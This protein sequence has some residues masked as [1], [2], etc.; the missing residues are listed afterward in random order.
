[1]TLPEIVLTEYTPS[2]LPTLQQWWKDKDVLEYVHELEHQLEGD[3]P[4]SKVGAGKYI[5]RRNVRFMVRDAVTGAAVGFICVQ[6]TGASWTER[7][8]EPVM[9]PFHGGVNIVIDPLRQHGG[10]GPAALKALFDHPKLENLVTLGG[11][12][13]A[14]NKASLG[15]LRKLGYVPSGPAVKGMVPFTVPGPAA[16]RS[17]TVSDHR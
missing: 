10:I 15:M 7:E 6:V 14:A 9:P 2:D 12:V 8:G 13:D 4:G 3:T 5:A 11:A 17:S 16:R 1:M